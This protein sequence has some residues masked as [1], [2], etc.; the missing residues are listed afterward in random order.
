MPRDVDWDTTLTG[1]RMNRAQRIIL[2]AAYK[3][4]V[5]TKRFN[6]DGVLNPD[7][8]ARLAAAR[9]TLGQPEARYARVNPM[10]AA[11]Q[12]SDDLRAKADLEWDAGYRGYNS[13]AAR[14]VF[15]RKADTGLWGPIE[16]VNLETQ[17]ACLDNALAAVEAGAGAYRTA[18]LAWA[19]GDIR[20]ALSGPRG[21]RWWRCA[22]PNLEII[23]RYVREI[24][25][26]VAASGVEVVV[27][28]IPVHSMVAK[29]GVVQ[30]LQGLGYVITEPSG[31]FETPEK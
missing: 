23:E 4:D 8:R 12:L 14:R 11:S 21:D 18:A 3:T 6:L 10:T 25:D 20:G 7:L 15:I 31:L 26:A 27:A 5:E 13:Q 17:L 16:P 24:E 30:R 28:G 1:W 22:A 9:V 29:G 19:Q 2:P